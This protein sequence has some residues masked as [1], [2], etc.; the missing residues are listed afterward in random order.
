MDTQVQTLELHGTEAMVP[1]Y[2]TERL[3][4]LLSQL[5]LVEQTM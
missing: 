4:T 2:K 5:I 3:I 1:F